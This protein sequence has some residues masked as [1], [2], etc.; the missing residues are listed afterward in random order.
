MLTTQFGLNLK[1]REVHES[2]FATQKVIRNCESFI[3][4]MCLQWGNIVK[5][6]KKVITPKKD[7]F[8]KS[9]SQITIF[10]HKLYSILLW[11]K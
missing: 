9:H 4:N 10:L 6:A 5:R 1:K 2:H 3:H 11:R 8:V 7:L